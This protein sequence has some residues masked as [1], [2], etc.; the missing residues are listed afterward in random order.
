MST[1]LIEVWVPGKA[2]PKGSLE[3]IGGGRMKE[4]NPHSKPWRK[5][6][7]SMFTANYMAL[8][9]AD[10]DSAVGGYEPYAGAV[11]VSIISLFP[12]T[13]DI[14]THGALLV[15]VTRDT[16]D[17]DK[18]TR[19]VLDALQDPCGGRVAVLAD[20]SQVVEIYYRAV[21]ARDAYSGGLWVKVAALDDDE[22]MR[23][24]TLTI[25]AAEAFRGF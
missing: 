10:P 12:A 2:R 16:G 14:P 4:S 7:A 19:N 18:I 3:H 15:P 21:Y 5:A 6:M 24:R 20:D 1:T 22:L 13:G 11:E 23:R 25:A 17:G 8:M 9:I